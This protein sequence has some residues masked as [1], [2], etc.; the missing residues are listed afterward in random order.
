MPQRC[1]VPVLSTVVPG[2][3]MNVAETDTAT[4]AL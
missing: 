1:A 4:V 3:T 2:G